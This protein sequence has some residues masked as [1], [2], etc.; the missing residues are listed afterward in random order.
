[1]AFCFVV[2][3]FLLVRVEEC[4]L[5]VRQV[6]CVVAPEVLEE[7]LARVHTVKDVA[8]E[9]HN[10]G[11]G[12]H[13]DRT[14]NVGYDLVADIANNVAD[15][16]VGG[17]LDVACIFSVEENVAGNNTEDVTDLDQCTFFLY[18][19][20]L[21]ELPSVLDRLGEDL[22]G[23]KLRDELAKGVDTAHGI[24]GLKEGT[25]VLCVEVLVHKRVAGETVGT[26]VC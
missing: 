11:A 22:E 17:P 1:M 14:D 19:E 4:L 26:S 12:V 20:C 9:E 23:F 15:R 24:E 16:L 5:S 21:V 25:A 10:V 6:D 13:H 7:V 2:Y 3:N 18:P 8:C